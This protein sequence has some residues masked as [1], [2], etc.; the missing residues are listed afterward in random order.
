M[1]VKKDRDFYEGDLVNQD[2]HIVEVIERLDPETD[3]Y[4]G[5]DFSH[6]GLVRRYKKEDLTEMTEKQAELVDYY[7]RSVW[8]S[9]GDV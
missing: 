6:G 3:E 1:T 9:L 7:L 4:I 8:L 5:I 2:G